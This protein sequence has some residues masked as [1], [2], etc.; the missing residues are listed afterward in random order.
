MSRILRRIAPLFAVALAAACAIPIPLN[1]YGLRVVRDPGSYELLAEREPDRRL[2]NLETAIP[3]IK[4]D[5]RYATPHNFMK[6][7]LYPVAQVWLRR[8]AAA[9]LADVE[10]ELAQKG[11]GLKVF[12]GY[13]PYR[14]TVR[15]WDEIHDSR[16]VADPKEGS[17]H[18]RGAAVDVSLIDLATGN[19]LVMPSPYDDFTERAHSD[20][21]NLPEDALRNRALLE[22]VMK[23]HGFTQLPTEW[24]HF[25]FRGWPQFDILDLPIESLSGLEPAG[26][27]SPHP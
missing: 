14:I 20:Y 25:D 26:A 24:W 17:R 12:D 11:L 4:L 13:R 16:Y 7:V 21:Q 18:N 3:G 10:R 8:P 6:H 27:V 19:E 5:V 22:D 2:V 23:R 15:M 1:P 9:A